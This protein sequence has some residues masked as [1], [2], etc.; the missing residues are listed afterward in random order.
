MR[1]GALGERYA[2][3]NRYTRSSRHQRPPALVDIHRCSSG[4]AYGARSVV[5]GEADGGF[6]NELTHLG[7]QAQLVNQH[8][9]H[10]NG[11]DSA[12]IDAKIDAQVHAL[13]EQE[14]KNAWAELQLNC[15]PCASAVVRPV[16]AT[17]PQFRGG[18]SLVRADPANLQHSLP[19]WVRRCNPWHFR[20]IC[21]MRP[22]YLRQKIVAQSKTLGVALDGVHQVP[23]PGA[24]PNYDR[25]APLSVN[26]RLLF[27]NFELSC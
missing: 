15:V 3:M 24:Y 23:A 16:T 21:R 11:K 26:G 10:K 5:E 17:L 25:T 4:F 13:L 19:R 7:H 8:K 14:S 22:R 27:F 12:K 6:S 2:S 9:S 18:K 20:Q 1:I